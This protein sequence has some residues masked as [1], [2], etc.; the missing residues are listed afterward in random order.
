M[1]VRVEIKN[2]LTVCHV[3]GEININS[4]PEIKKSFDKLIGK[5]T[6]TRRIA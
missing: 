6:Q 3:D 4:S 2:G 1:A 5:K